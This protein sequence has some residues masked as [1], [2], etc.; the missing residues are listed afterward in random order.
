[1]EIKVGKKYR[2][3]CSQDCRDSWGYSYE[4]EKD[5]IITILE[6]DKNFKDTHYCLIDRHTFISKEQFKLT[7]EEINDE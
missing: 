6:C 4:I 2:S 5:K 3:K 7:F 1:M